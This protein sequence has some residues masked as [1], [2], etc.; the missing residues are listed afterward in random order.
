MK[1]I[2]V[3]GAG[4]IGGTLAA[5]FSRTGHD[6][7]MVDK[8]AE[9][10]A[11][12]NARGLRI[13]GPV[14]QADIRAPARLPDDVT[15][16]H[17]TVFLCVKAQHTAAAA[18][19]LVRHLAPDG[20]VV[21]AQNGLNE[22]VIAD[23]VGA[24]RTMGCFVNFGADYLGPGV[25]HYSGLGAVVIGSPNG[26]VTTRARD[27][28][29]LLLSFAPQ[30]VLTENIWGYLWGKMVYGALLFATAVT[31]DSIAD[32]LDAPEWRP[33]LTALAREVG[34]VAA[35][36]GID[37]EGFD[38]FDPGAFAP[39]AENARLMQSFDDMVAHN[40]RSAKSHSGIWRDLAV[41]RRPTE[42]DALLGAVVDHGRANG[43]DTT[44]CARLIA[45]IHEIELGRRALG[46]DNL[47]ALAQSVPQ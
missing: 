46:P 20:V 37:T 8:D 31:D 23:I 28:H 38:G 25:V 40:R 36:E 17:D 22:S 1:P 29:T 14:W 44:L 27:L 39:G 41:R 13:E 16:R 42:V 26:R 32:V 4:A 34:S 5:A 6:V 19:S 15:G 30:A 18:G 9:H 43:V 11:A 24:R 2:L 45:V 7:I 10:V 47:A 12:I 35:A 33:V 21:S 3:W